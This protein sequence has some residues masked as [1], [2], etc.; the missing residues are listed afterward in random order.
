MRQ[1]VSLDH[2]NLLLCGNF[3]RIVG[4]Y[5]VRFLLIWR[6]PNSVLAGGC[7]SGFGCCF[8]YSLVDCD[9]CFDCFGFVCFAV[10]LGRVGT[11][12]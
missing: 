6:F 1:H 10:L 9:C 8:G 3:F 4:I 11:F 12:V 2:N 5:H 7:F